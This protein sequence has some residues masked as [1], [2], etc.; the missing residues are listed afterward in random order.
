VRDIDRRTFL[1]HTGR[2]LALAALAPTLS[3]CA[4]VLRWSESQGRVDVA[5]DERASTST[6]ESASTP[7][8]EAGSTPTSESA[9]TTTTVSA[10]ATTVTGTP[11]LAVFRGD[12]PDLN[13]R[14]AVAELGGMERFV[15]PGAKVVV[16]PNVLTGRPPEYA[17]T[18]NPLVVAAVIRMCLE[19][20]ADEVVVLDNPT[21]S[22][23][24]AFQEAGLTQAVQ[25]AGGKLKYL[26]NRDFERVDIPEGEAI[27]SW[28]FVT[29]ALEADTLINLPIAKTHGLAGLTLAMKNLMGIMGDSRGQIHTDFAR[30]ITDVNTL[31]KPDL[32][33]LDAYR[34]LM[35]NGPTGGNLDDV[36]LLKT[37]VAG[38]SQVAIDM[39]GATLMGWKPADLPSLVEAGRRGLGEIDPAKYTVFEGTA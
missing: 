27:T 21:S 19:A 4:R 28:P 2:W 22:A 26:S 39:Y 29:A 24:G 10:P 13:V 12:S 32:V 30:K 8:S 1:L 14:A 6:S 34:A 3:G 18:T 9:A 38:T 17:T 7:M 33:I 20:G 31:V 23:R 25:E 36:Q 37:A 11:D 35:R 5:E 15:R 16:K